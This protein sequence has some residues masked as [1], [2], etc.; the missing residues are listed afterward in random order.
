MR[1][2]VSVFKSRPSTIDG[3]GESLSSGM[4]ELSIV[5][6]SFLS[7][8]KLTVRLTS[9]TVLPALSLG[10]VPS[11][12]FSSRFQ[13]SKP[14]LAPPSSVPWQGGEGRSVF[15][16]FKERARVTRV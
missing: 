13:V 14:L 16:E 9:P 7:V 11:R 2:S 6:L 4:S 15:G 10:S 3:V 12:L 8:A 1:R 5:S